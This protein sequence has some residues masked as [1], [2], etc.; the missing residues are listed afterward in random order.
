[1]VWLRTMDGKRGLLGGA[2]A[3]AFLLSTGI[4]GYQLATAPGGDVGVRGIGPAQL[5]RPTPV[6][7]PAPAPAAPAPAAPGPA[8]SGASVPGAPGSAPLPSPV[9]AALLR[10]GFSATV[11][12]G[13]DVPDCVAN[14]YGQTQA[15]LRAH[16]CLGVRRALV[17]VNGAGPGEALVAVA[18]ARMADPAS[19]Q[20]LKTVLDRPGSG[21]IDSL[22]P[23]VP[24]TGQYYASRIDG[25]T[26]VNADVHPLV[27][28]LTAAQL[29]KI[30]ADALG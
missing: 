19:A 12:A 4:L 8:A 20:G 14:S 11:W 10:D 17:H 16:R 15:Y 25:T 22:N 6:A 1:M 3:L 23:S 30:A 21:N 28:G 18:W 29:K 7:A 26:A 24:F 27:P 5:D 9:A 13:S 2:V